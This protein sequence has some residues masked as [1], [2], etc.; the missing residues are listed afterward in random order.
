MASRNVCPM[1]DV[2]QDLNYICVVNLCSLS[3]PDSGLVMGQLKDIKP[4]IN[5]EMQASYNKEWVGIQHGFC[6]V[7]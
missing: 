4:F 2:Y 1:V 6:P 5:Q 3:K 7:L